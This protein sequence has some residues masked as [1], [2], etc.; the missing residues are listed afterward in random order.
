MRIKVDRKKCSGCHLC[1]MACSLFHMGV[2]NPERSAIRIEKDD[3]E[4]SVHRPI[5]CRQCK[6]M[7]CL[8]GEEVNDKS[9]KG[10]FLWDEGRS[11]RCPFH[12]LTVFQ[13]NAYHC[14]LCGGRPQCVK[15]CTPGAI[16]IG[17]GPGPM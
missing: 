15:V 7:K 1:E 2:M 4:T 6:E 13:G 9:E 16:R 11:D 8:D 17:K 3:L 5:V 14:D 12:A 10:K